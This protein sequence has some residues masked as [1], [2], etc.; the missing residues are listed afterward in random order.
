MC[1][2]QSTKANNRKGHTL[3]HAEKNIMLHDTIFYF[4]VSDSERTYIFRVPL[5]ALPTLAMFVH[6]FNTH[7]LFLF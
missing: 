1:R 2:L 3:K 7:V 4:I 5:A 6:D